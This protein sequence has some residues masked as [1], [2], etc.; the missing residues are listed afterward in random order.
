MKKYTLIILWTGLSFGLSAQANKIYEMQKTF[1]NGYIEYVEHYQTYDGTMR[2]PKIFQFYFSK[3]EKYS[4]ANLL[5]VTDSVRYIYTGTCSYT[6]N[7]ET[8]TIIVDTSAKHLPFYFIH[9]QLPELYDPRLAFKG[10]GY[11]RKLSTKENTAFKNK[12]YIYWGMGNKRGRIA[13]T[14]KLF[15]SN[16]S[17]SIV[18][19]EYDESKYLRDSVQIKTSI[20]EHSDFNK[21]KYS[22]AKLYNIEEYGNEFKMNYLISYEERLKQLKTT[23][24][25]TAP[26]FEL[27]VI[28]TDS[29]LKLSDYKGKWILLD[30]WF[31]KC[32]PCLMAFPKVEELYHRFHSKGLEVIGINIDTNDK[33]LSDFVAAK[34]VPFPMLNTE[35]KEVAKLYSVSAYP[36][37]FLLNP[38]LEIVEAGHNITEIM[39]YLKEYLK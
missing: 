19:Y 20:V 9:A 25:T 27:P 24:S 32:K 30:F 17:K 18:K 2:P 26:D 31:M 3:E 8:K 6:I 35:N 21:E 16:E 23:I 7:Y 38:Q 28:G 1:K 39:E 15:F 5:N 14:R 37:F 22:E 29:T 12:S 10:Y 34:N 33:V 36:T 11:Q 4:K 13:A